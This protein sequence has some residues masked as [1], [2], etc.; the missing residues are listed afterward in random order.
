MEAVGV[1]QYLGMNVDQSATPFLINTDYS[2][3][4]F[5]TTRRIL[6]VMNG[7]KHYR[8]LTVLEQGYFDSCQEYLVQGQPNTGF[9]WAAYTSRITAV[10]K[11][12]HTKIKYVNMGYTQ[13]YNRL[14][15]EDL[16]ELSLKAFIQ[17][18]IGETPVESFDTYVQEWYNSGGQ[19]LTDQANDIQREKQRGQN[20]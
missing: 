20:R 14:T 7:R 6:D 16:E 15:S 9:L 1:G 8:D 4:V 18:I 19:E 13:E 2:D 10:N 12:I 17:I 3:A 11:L 5:R